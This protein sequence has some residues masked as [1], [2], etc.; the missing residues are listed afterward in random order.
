MPHTV[1]APHLNR[2]V[3][4]GGCKLPPLHRP[5]I[6]LAHFLDMQSIPPS[7]PSLDLSGPAMS[8]IQNI[9]GND[10]Y[11]DCVFAEE[12][13]FVGIATGNAGTLYSYSRAQT[14]ALYTA[15]TGFNPDIPSTDQGGD[16]IATMNYLCTHPYADGTE[17][18][19][20]AE[21]D[22]TNIPEVM[23]ALEAFGNLKLWLGLPD[24]YINPF[25][26]KNGFV[27]DQAP[28][29]ANNGHCIGSSGYNSTNVAIVGANG[30]GVQV[31]TWGLIGT[32]TW[33]AL[34]ALCSDSGG[35]GAAVRITPDWIIKASQKTPTGFNYSNLISLFNFIFNKSIPVPTPAPTPPSPPAPP[36]PPTPAPPVPPTP[37][38]PVPTPSASVTLSEAQSWATSRLSHGGLVVTRSAAIQDVNQGLSSN[39][40]SSHG[41]EPDTNPETPTG[42]RLRNL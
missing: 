10:A 21:V 17:L 41:Q 16:P 18:V 42:K 39:W 23:F 35:G 29:N 19:G 27:W 40:P 33:R 5:R 26:S 1:F 25:P 22:V 4:I 9:E 2:N 20:Y 36:V 37:A 8:V 31:M 15:V 12:A 34:A 32:I 6:R 24:S 30:Q 28:P 3:V 11:G 14:L 7:P 38:P 13:H